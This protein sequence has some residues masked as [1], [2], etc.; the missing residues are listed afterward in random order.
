MWDWRS[1]LDRADWRQAAQAARPYAPGVA[2]AAAVC[3]APLLLLYLIPPILGLFAPKLD[4]GVDLY[5]VNRPLA[6][7]FLDT[8]GA[9][10]GH[11]GAVVG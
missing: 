2:I 11:R 9:E 3:A 7:T 1:L 10:V 4:P 6:F 8:D 5:A